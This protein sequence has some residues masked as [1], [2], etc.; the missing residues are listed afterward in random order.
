M[1]KKYFKIIVGGVIIVIGLFTG[2]ITQEDLLNDIGLSNLILNNTTYNI[3]NENINFNELNRYKVVS[4]IDGD[5][6]KINYNS[7]A[8]KVRLIGIDTPE[9]VS[10]NKEKNSIYGKEASEYTK[11]RLEGKDI[12]IE[13]DV[14]ETDKYGRLLAYVY[15]ED[16]TMYNKELIE[17]GY[18]QVATYPPNV[19]Y[20]EEFKQIQEQARNNKVGFW[21]T[22]IFK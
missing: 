6:I 21:S 13:F 8:K 11:N 4:V 3:S 17:K 16:G 2:I 22:N 9:S 12:F 7:S 19:K 10:P 5:T 18:A 1:K 14:Q 15:L 20:V